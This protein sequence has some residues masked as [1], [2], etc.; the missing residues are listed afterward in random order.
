MVVLH[1]ALLLPTAASA[2]EGG[3]VSGRVLDDFDGTPIGFA[4]VVVAA[5]ASG[6]TVSGVLAGADG[7]FVVRGLAAGRYTIHSSFVGYAPGEDDVLV[8][9]LN[10]SQFDI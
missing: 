9:E 6:D 3:T 8:S 5:A 1:A 10:P 2:Q 4:A 7:R